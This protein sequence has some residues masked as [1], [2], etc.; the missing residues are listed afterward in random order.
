MIDSIPDV[1]QKVSN[2]ATR[3]QGSAYFKA[4]YVLPWLGTFGLHWCAGRFEVDYYLASLRKPYVALCD[5][6]TSAQPVCFATAIWRIY[7]VGGGVGL[8]AHAPFRIAT[9]RTK[10]AMPETKIG[11]APDVGASYFLSRLDG[12]IGTYLALTGD[13]LVGRAALW[14]VISSLYK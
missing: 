6:I 13:V 9:E 14:A 8:I 3:Q 5:G 1:I 7:L 11:Y 12:E 2:P 4:E 10:M